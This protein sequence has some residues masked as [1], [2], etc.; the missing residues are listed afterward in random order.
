[1]YNK[2]LKRR[3]EMIYEASNYEEMNELSKK[4]GFIKVNW[5]EDE[6]CENKIKEELGLKS[7]CII[8]DEKPN[9]KCVYCGKDAKVK[10]YFGRQY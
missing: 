1:M 7:R 3:N 4:P 2:A 5:C 8:E 9:G 6:T 10:I